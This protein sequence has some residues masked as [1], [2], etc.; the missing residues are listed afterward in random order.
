YYISWYP[1]CKLAQTLDKDGRKLYDKVHKWPVNHLKKAIAKNKS[2]SDCV[3]NITHRKF[4][5]DNIKAMAAFIPS[6]KCFLR[7][8]NLKYRVSGGVILAKGKSDIDDPASYLHQRSEIGPIA[9]GSYITIDTGKYCTAPLFAIKA[10]D[11]VDG[12]H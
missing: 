7:N 5:K 9:N 4:I 10:A 6:L 2:I 3:T 12:I 8:R 11:L 1:L